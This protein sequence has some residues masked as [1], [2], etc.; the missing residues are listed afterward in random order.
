LS[1]LNFGT[2]VAI[3]AEKDDRT[4]TVNISTIDGT[5]TIVISSIQDLEE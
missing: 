3:S 2:G 4:V 1:D 5:T